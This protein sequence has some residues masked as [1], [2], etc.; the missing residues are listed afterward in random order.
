MQKTKLAAAIDI[1]SN[2]IRMVIAQIDR[3]GR[4][5]ILEELRQSTNIGKDTFTYGKI[6]PQVIHETCDI[7]KKF[8]MKMQEYRVENVRA[9]ATSG[10]REAENKSFVLEQIRMKTGFEV[11]VINNAEERFLTAKAI[12]YYMPE[13]HQDARKKVLLVNIGSGGLEVSS[14]VDKKLKGTYYLKL[15][16]LRLKEILSDIEN[17]TLHFPSIMEEFIEAKM[18][19]VKNHIESLDIDG[20]IALGSGVNTILGLSDSKKVGERNEIIQKTEIDRIYGEIFSKTAIQISKKHDI[21]HSEA[22]VLLPSVMIF[23]KLL[24]MTSAKFMYAPWVSLRHGILV[25]TMDKSYKYGINKS[26]DEDIIS[27]TR[28]IGEKYNY[29]KV[30]SEY[31]ERLALSIFDQTKKLH[32]LKKNHRKYLQVASILHDV[33]KIMSYENHNMNSYN[34]I[35]AQNIIGFSNREVEI[36]ANIARYHGEE[37]PK[38]YHDT[39]ERLGFADQIV[40]AKLSAI[41]K[42]A[43]A[44]DKSHA[45]KVE[46]LKISGRDEEL[47][48]KIKSKKDT[49]LEKWTFIQKTRLFEEVMGTRIIIKAK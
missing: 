35:K 12:K 45:Q 11:E 49:F 3:E 48:F 28:Y 43:D 39:F 31:V 5:S 19:P 17:I 20:F 7:L 22:Q 30:H 29:E 42:L 47:V 8:V 40:V 16:S 18:L 37:E 1:G 33:G 4:I 10:I 21:V 23:K 15:G 41:L 6:S 24:D 13:G 34:I 26:L 38:P 32:K 2:R 25:D 9:V 46:E 14:F 44:L 27:S 36:I